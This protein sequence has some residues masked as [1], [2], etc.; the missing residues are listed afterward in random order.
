MKSFILI[1]LLFSLPFISSA[2]TSGCSELIIVNSK[3][4]GATGIRPIQAPGARLRALNV[5]HAYVL[6]SISLP[7]GDKCFERGKPIEIE[8]TDDTRISLPNDNDANCSTEGLINLG[9]QH[10]HEAE[11]EQLKT[12]LVRTIHISSKGEMSGLTLTAE[13]QLMLRD[14]VNCL[15]ESL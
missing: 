9:G 10:K 2:Q 12:K 5:E 14:Q 4:N 6:I 1:L 8:F 7:E 15:T 13:N 11:L 3:G